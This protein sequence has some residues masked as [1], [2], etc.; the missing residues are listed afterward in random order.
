MAVEISTSSA[1]ILVRNLDRVSV[2]FKN[3]LPMTRSCTQCGRIQHL[4]VYLVCSPENIHGTLT[5]PGDLTVDLLARVISFCVRGA[6]R[7]PRREASD[8]D[9]KHTSAPVSGRACSGYPPAEPSMKKRFC[10]NELSRP[11]F[12]WRSDLEFLEGSKAK[13]QMVYAAAEAEKL[14]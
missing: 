6:G 2:A 5:A 14:F 7:N 1:L 13:N 3:G 4:S 10:F 8:C 11:P 12:W 9:I